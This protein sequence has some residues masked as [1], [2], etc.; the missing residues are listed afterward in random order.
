MSGTVRRLRRAVALVCL[1]L[2]AGLTSPDVPAAQRVGVDSAVNPNAMGI[3]PGALPRRLV[4]GQDVVF[5]ERITTEEQGQ[6]Q[7]LFVDESTLSVGPNA[8]MVIDQFVYDPNAGTGK[9]VA[10][11]GRGVFRFVG[12]KL[13]KQDNA[14]TMRTP[15]ATIGIRGG[16]MLVDQGPDGRLEVIFVYGKGVTITGLNGVSQTIYRPGFAVSVAGPGASP[17]D[18]GPAPPGR[19]AALLAQLDGRTGGS[20]GAPVAPTE[21]TVASSGIA[22]VVSANVGASVQAAAKN[23]PNQPQPENVNPVVTQTQLNNQNVSVSGATAT[24]VG[25]G[26]TVPLNQFFTNPTPSG[27]PISNG[28]NASGGNGGFTA[29]GG[30]SGGSVVSGGSTVSG[31]GAGS[32]GGTVSGGGSGGSGGG[33]SGGGGT[34]GSGGG[35][36][37]IPNVAGGYAD[38][39]SQGTALGFVGPVSSYQGASVVNGVLSVPGVFSFP[40]AAGGAALSA[41]GAGTMSPLGPVTGATFLS[42]DNSFF[43]AYLVP[44][45]NTSQ[46]EVIYGGTPVSAAYYQATSANPTYLAFTVVPDAALGST[47]PFIRNQAGGSLAN[48]SVSPLILATPSNNTFST[49]GAATKALQASLAIDGSGNQQSSV[50]VVLVGNVVGSPANLQGVVHGSYLASNPT[51]SAAVQPTRINSYYGSPADGN[52]NSFYG[53]NSISGFALAPGAGATNA[54]EVNTGNQTT[55]ANYQ[56][57]EPVVTTPVPAVANGTQ[58]TQNLSGYFGGIMTKEPTAGVGAPVPYAVTGNT[59]ISTNASNLQI[60]ATLTGG[61][62]FT[63]K[64]SGIPAS[65]GIV[66]QFGTSQSGNTFARQAFIN[67]NLFAVLESPTTASTVNGVTITPSTAYPNT[68]PNLY[69]VTQTAAPATALLPSGL[70]SSCQYLQWGYWGGELDTLA[71]GSGS[72]AARTDVGHINFWVAGTQLT[73]MTDISSLQATNFT[74]TYNGNLIGTVVNNGA[75]YLAAGGLQAT[76]QFG[77]QTGSFAVSKYDNQSFT[78]AGHVPLNGSNYTFG[79]KNGAISGAV[80]GGFYG[81]MAAETGGNFAFTA[82]PTYT[83]AG[84]FAAKR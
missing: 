30:G 15:T 84:I 13:S 67:D 61:D 66:M 21:V 77:T 32:G 69:L 76:Y 50:L 19:T 1:L 37:N 71:S 12:G 65:S 59:S 42:P 48:P 80:N 52:G 82:G 6:T 16:V 53:K 33:G 72:V 70:C 47:I 55:T 60:A 18:P 81:P 38:T 41:S 56:F 8:N 23:Q 36:I 74:G 25:G 62:P 46:R 24:P 29:L 7:I 43:F 4:L 9:L 51:G 63:S 3:P 64:T 39:G 34:G 2:G 44:V 10:S 79:F 20:G 40:L 5:N 68:N 75:Q 45:S 22:N 54:I 27:T 17:S 73:S 26:S 83:T 49:T 58:T 35:G 28:T 78:V 14:V 31:G 11:L 57:V